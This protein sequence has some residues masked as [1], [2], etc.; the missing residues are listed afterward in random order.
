MKP[1]KGETIIE[2]VITV[3]I[4]GGAF[5]FLTFSPEAADEY[6]PLLLAVSATSVGWF[7]GRW[8]L[9]RKLLKAINLVPSANN[10]ISLK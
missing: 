3:F 6:Y 4:L 7:L 5:L 9:R 10:P 8:E 2:A 1:K